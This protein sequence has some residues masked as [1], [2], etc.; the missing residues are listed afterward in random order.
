M[1]T[2]VMHLCQGWSRVVISSKLTHPN[3]TTT[4]AKLQISPGLQQLLHSIACIGQHHITCTLQAGR[5]GEAVMGVR[6]FGCMIDLRT[7]ICVMYRY[8]LG[9]GSDGIGRNWYIQALNS[10]SVKFPRNR[11]NSHPP[12]DPPA[13]PQSARPTYPTFEAEEVPGSGHHSGIALHCEDGGARTLVVEVALV[14][15]T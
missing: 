11:L 7:R 3:G 5:N 6:M 4:V 1:I 15:A 12:A 2:R 14:V 13:A 8:I 10:N 9:D